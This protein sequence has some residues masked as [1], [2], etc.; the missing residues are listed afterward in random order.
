MLF[1]SPAEVRS[2]IPR[3]PFSVLHA[4]EARDAREGCIVMALLHPTTLFVGL[5]SRTARHRAALGKRGECP[6]LG[7]EAACPHGQD[8]VLPAHPQPGTVPG[9][10][11]AAAY[12][13]RRGRRPVRPL[14]PA[15]RPPPM[16]RGCR[17][18]QSRGL[19]HRPTDRPLDTAT[20]RTPVDVSDAGLDVMVFDGPA[21]PLGRS[22]TICTYGPALCV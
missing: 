5:V 8:S 22:D 2:E 9:L 12:T 13:R 1:E 16:P 21:H 20:P 19:I 14:R 15:P 6:P 3:I 10:R 7:S 11:G 17:G 18:A 4:R